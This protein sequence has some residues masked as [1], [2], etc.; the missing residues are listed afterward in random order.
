MSKNVAY[1]LL[2]NPVTLFALKTIIK[3]YAYNYSDHRFFNDEMKI[4]FKYK[5]IKG[6]LP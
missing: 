6:I 3:Y 1:P 2:L 4:S 5:V